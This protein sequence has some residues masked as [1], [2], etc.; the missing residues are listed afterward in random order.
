MSLADQLRA[1]HKQ[2]EAERAAAAATE[3]TA[4][5]YA[6]AQVYSGFGRIEAGCMLDHLSDLGYRLVKE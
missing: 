4:M 2:Q 6:G 1:A 3:E 5:T